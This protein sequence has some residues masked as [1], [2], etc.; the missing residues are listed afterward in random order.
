MSDNQRKFPRFDTDIKVVVV[1][2]DNH[3]HVGSVTNVSAGGAVVQFDLGVEID[4]AHMNIGGAVQLNANNS[5]KVPGRIIRVGDEG[6]A[7]QFNS[8]SGDV[9]DWISKVVD[10][11]DKRRR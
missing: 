5:P 7:M 2:E 10:E 8:A 4:P 3:E 11:A 6:I 1:D 9:F